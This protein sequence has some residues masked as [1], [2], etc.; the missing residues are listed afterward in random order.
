MGP[1]RGR[2]AGR[3]HGCARWPGAGVTN[4]SV[5]LNLRRLCPGAWCG[6]LNMATLPLN[7]HEWVVCCVAAQSCAGHLSSVS[8]TY[9][10]CE[11]W[12]GMGEQMA[13]GLVLG[14]LR[15]SLLAGVSAGRESCSVGQQ[16]RECKTRVW[17]Q[18]KTVLKIWG[19]KVTISPGHAVGSQ[20]HG[21]A[22]I[23][24][25]SCSAHAGH[26]LWH[27]CGGGGEEQG[28]ELSLPRALPCRSHTGSAPGTGSGRAG[29]LALVTNRKMTQMKADP[30]S[31]GGRVPVTL[32]ALNMLLINTLLWVGM[33]DS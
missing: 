19:I 1:S 16:Q 9:F 29:A 23:H 7:K 22:Q 11:I 33:A 3:A 10:H 15:R 6:M 18:R 24:R 8:D 27:H 26:G 30:C 13:E 2:E 31:A 21:A 14:L 12:D 4:H 25:A 28:A 5:C 17:G 20:V 32:L